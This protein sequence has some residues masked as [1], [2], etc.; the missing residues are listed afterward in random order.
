MW[1]WRKGDLLMKG[2]NRNTRFEKLRKNGFYKSNLFSTPYFTKWNPSTGASINDF[3]CWQKPAN[4]TCMDILK[5]V[6]AQ[7][8][9]WFAGFLVRVWWRYIRLR[10][11][12]TLKWRQNFELGIKQRGPFHYLLHSVSFSFSKPLI[13]TYFWGIAGFG[14]LPQQASSLTCIDALWERSIYHLQH[15]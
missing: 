11:D 15:A 7:A 5:Y 2:N 8:T 9:D 13:T 14:N 1:V 6:L 3:A 10:M 4:L 12:D